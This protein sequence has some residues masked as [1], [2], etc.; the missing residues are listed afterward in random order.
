MKY[1]TLTRIKSESGDFG[2]F[3][4]FCLGNL[5]CYSGE[6][7]YQG[8]AKNISCLRP[9]PADESVVY[10]LQNTYSPEHKTNLYHFTKMKLEDGSW[11][12]L[13]DGRTVAEIHSGNLCGDI[14]KRMLKQIL[15]CCLLGRAIV[16]FKK[17]EKFTAFGP[18]SPEKMTLCVLEADQIGVSS[19]KDA[20]NAFELEAAGDDIELT[21]SWVS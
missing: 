4:K 15:G 9:G 2:T 11:G 16:T 3:G 8:D 14:S 18:E 6:L 21:V 7:S 12:A 13:P 19:S 10:L 1:G 5:Q 20:L 17:G